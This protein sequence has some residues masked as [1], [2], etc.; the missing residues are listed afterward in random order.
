MTG[1][2][3]GQEYQRKGT[4]KS[5]L[6]SLGKITDKSSSYD[7]TSKSV[8]TAMMQ[9]NPEKRREL[10]KATK[11]LTYLE[12]LFGSKLRLYCSTFFKALTL[13]LNIYRTSH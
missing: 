8:E 10:K 1:H 11:F 6:G 5:K 13:E 4:L 3:A 9:I 7:S 2:D 12:N